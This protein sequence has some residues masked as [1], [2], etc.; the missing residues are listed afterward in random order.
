V[1]P[2]VQLPIFVKFY[3]EEKLHSLEIVSLHVNGFIATLVIFPFCIYM[4][5]ISVVM[6]SIIDFFQHKSPLK[7]VTEIRC[8]PQDKPESRQ[9]A[10]SDALCAN[11]PH[12]RVSKGHINKFLQ[13]YYN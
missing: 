10:K 1:K 12:K 3:L 7:R 4:C 9:P 6:L 11:K 8:E 5:M 13:V 2:R